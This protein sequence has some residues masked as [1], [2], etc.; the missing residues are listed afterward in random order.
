M[1]FFVTYFLGEISKF[2]AEISH[3]VNNTH[4]FNELGGSKDSAKFPKAYGMS[5]AGFF[6][7]FENIA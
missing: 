5:H 4:G 1:H 6:N 3:R 2:I 7:N